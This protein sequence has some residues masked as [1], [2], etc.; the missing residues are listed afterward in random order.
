[1]AREVIKDMLA[2]GAKAAPPVVVTT[3]SIAS[4]WTMNHTVYALTIVY[5]LLQIGWLVWRW[6]RAVQGREVRGD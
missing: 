2:E 5:L 4:D 3:A 1:M 6:Y